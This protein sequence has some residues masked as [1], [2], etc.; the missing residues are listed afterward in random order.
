MALDNFIMA[1]TESPTQRQCVLASENL[2]A[3][4]NNEQCGFH[5]NHHLLEQQGIFCF[6]VFWISGGH[7]L[8]S[9][10]KIVKF[11]L[12]LPEIV[13]IE[14]QNTLHFQGNDVLW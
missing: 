6:S 11:F 12:L 2:L 5:M 13:I 4:D 8:K 14:L 9:S 3:L 1:L 10:A 7:G